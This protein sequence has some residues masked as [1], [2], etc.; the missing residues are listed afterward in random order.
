MWDMTTNETYT[1]DS[2]CIAYVPMN[3]FHQNCQVLKNTRQNLK[4]GGF[5]KW[6]DEWNKFS[7]YQYIC[8]STV[9][10]VRR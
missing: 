9:L 4:E 5:I 2:A 10:V 7:A 3:K 1:S 6:R 8:I